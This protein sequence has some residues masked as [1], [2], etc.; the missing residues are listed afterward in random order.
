MK[1][2]NICNRVLRYRSF[3]ACFSFYNDDCNTKNTCLNFSIP[4]IHIEARACESVWS[5]HKYLPKE[6]C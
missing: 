4:T 6:K 5:P 1:V 3:V 2:T